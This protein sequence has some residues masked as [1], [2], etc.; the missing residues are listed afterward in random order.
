MDLWP[1]ARSIDPAGLVQAVIPGATLAAMN[2]A[3]VMTASA[4]VNSWL[5]AVRIR[6]ANI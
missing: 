5:C 1:G 6:A 4:A 3:E 2:M